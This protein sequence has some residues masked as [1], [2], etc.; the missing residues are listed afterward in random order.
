[1]TTMTG[2]LGITAR[3]AVLI[4]LMAGVMGLSPAVAD[5]AEER[6]YCITVRS[7]DPIEGDVLAA[8]R[9]GAATAEIVEAGACTPVEAE[10]PTPPEL[11]PVDKTSVEHSADLL[12]TIRIQAEMPEGYDRD[13]FD[14]WIDAD[15]DGCHARDEV[16]IE[17]SLTEVRVMGGCRLRGGSWYSVFDG[18]KT[19]DPSEFDVDHVVPLAEAWRSGARQWTDARREAFANDLSDERTLRAVSASSNRSKS[20]GDPAR[21]LPPDEGFHCEYVQD[22]I[23]IKATWDLAVDRP[24]REAIG[25][26][27]GGCAEDSATVVAELPEES[28]PTATPRP[29]KKQAEPKAGSNAGPEDDCHPSYPGVCIKPPPPDLDCGDIK[30]RRFEVKGSDPHRFDGDKDGVG[31]ES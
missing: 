16:L 25:E 15:G 23:A 22:W 3:V 6:H 10:Q 11:G 26:I 24:E 7:E 19:S 2:L 29:K 9:A 13:L 14:H 28:R 8:I 21:W 27:L 5:A 18:R 1:M 12:L 4:A 30:Q 17:E 20:D 31:C